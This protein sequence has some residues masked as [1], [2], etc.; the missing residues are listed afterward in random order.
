MEEPAVPEP[1]GEDDA[2][3]PLRFNRHARPIRGEMPYEE[4]G[5]PQTERLDHSPT[6]EP[7]AYE[8]PRREIRPLPGA[9]DPNDLPVS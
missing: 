4:G 1:V 2:L 5:T 9:V 7:V 3:S 6:K 8:A